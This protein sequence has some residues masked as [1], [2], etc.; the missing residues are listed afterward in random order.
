[1]FM[2]LNNFQNFFEAMNLK[3]KKII[4]FIC[5][6]VFLVSAS[7]AFY[8]KIRPAV[9]AEV[10]D[11]TAMN[12]ISG[13]GFRYEPDGSLIQDDIIAFQGPLY[14]FFLAGI[15]KFFGHYYEIVWIMQ[16]LLRAAS[17]FFIFLIAK[18]IFGEDKRRI[19]YF[20]AVFFGFYPDLIEMNAMLMTETLYLFF[21]LFTV[22]L[23]LNLFSG[24]NL[25][26]TF[27]LTL[28]FGLAVLTR[29]T[30]GFFL[31]L[32][33]FYFYK[34]KT[35]KYLFIFLTLFLIILTP[36]T[37]RNYL[38]Y[39]EFLPTMANFGFNFWVGNHIGGDGEGGNMPELFNAVERL[40]VIGANYYALEQFKD[41]L[42][43]HPFLYVKFTVIRI[44]KYFSV[45]RP[46]GF[47]FY[48]TGLSQFVF[49]TSSAL[50]SMIVF[51]FGFGGIFSS[52]KDLKNNNKLIY[53]LLFAV[54]TC[55]S[56]VPI[57][58]ETRYRF[59]IYPFMAIFAGAFVD[60]FLINKKEY[61]KYFNASVIL[62]V[63]LAA[64]D[65]SLEYN[66]I[67][68]KINKIFYG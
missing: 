4:L 18:K 51:I 16:S 64:I 28:I 1:M 33:L 27:F 58:I 17:A 32:F 41:F 3:E 5:F 19:G 37:V 39:H 11:T 12:M 47:W 34:Q 43:K 30:V 14:E 53:F 68:D 21:L 66:K 40:G 22:Y 29:S 8:F 50:W 61:F 52:V 67:F 54:L 57:L 2:S 62:I 48:Q 23:F 59:P 44:I 24:I 56:V 36:W 60:G 9:D 45:I 20:A 7:Y 63:L 13:K 15:Y 10:Y 49:I 46:S 31:P 42:Y 55:F 25:K 38:T 35:F 65:F 26:K 6:L